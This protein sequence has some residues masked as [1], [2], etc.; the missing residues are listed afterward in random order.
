[1]HADIRVDKGEQAARGGRRSGITC[2]GGTAPCLPDQPRA[3]LRHEGGQ[4]GGSRFGRTVIHYDNLA[5][6]SVRVH[7]GIQADGQHFHAAVYWNN[8]RERHYTEAAGKR[9]QGLDA[10]DSSICTLNLL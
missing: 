2:H 3:F 6:G 7:Q 5:R 1:M 10:K 9:G 8:Y 4:G